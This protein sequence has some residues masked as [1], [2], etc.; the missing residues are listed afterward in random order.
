MLGLFGSLNLAAR[1][2]QTQQRG[3]EV[4][5]LVD[6]VG[7]RYTW[8]SIRSVLRREQNGFPIGTFIKFAVT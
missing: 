1:S 7:V 3:V 6:D 4:R 5:V 2:L 8:P